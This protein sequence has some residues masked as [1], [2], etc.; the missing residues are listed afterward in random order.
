MKVTFI[1]K[2]GEKRVLDFVEG[3][4]LLNLALRNDIKLNNMCE[5]NA[6]CGGCHV[7]IDNYELLGEIS[8]KEE[9]GLDMAKGVKINSRLACQI[10]L[11]SRTDNLIVRIPQN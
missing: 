1:L 6:V 9:E 11:S 5:G 4:T 2:N 8:E 10:V 3:E 7:Y